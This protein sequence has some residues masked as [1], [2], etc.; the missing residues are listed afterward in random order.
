MHPDDDVARNIRNQQRNAARPSKE[1]VE[2]MHR[3]HLADEGCH[4]CGEDDPEKLTDEYAVA[5]NCPAHQSP[6]G[7]R[8][9][10][11]PSRVVC[12]EGHLSATARWWWKQQH[13]A[14]EQ[15]TPLVVYDCRVTNWASPPTEG[16]TRTRGGYQQPP[17]EAP[18]ECVC[19]AP[20]RSIVYPRTADD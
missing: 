1:E 9:G 3:K 18:V 5:H 2:R 8:G 16:K 11:D 15:G 10:R 6:Y 14:D 12:T 4:L 17:P 13:R 19:G 20:V 7:G